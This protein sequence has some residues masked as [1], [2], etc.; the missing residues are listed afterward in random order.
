[1]NMNKEKLDNIEAKLYEILNEI[2]E[3][4]KQLK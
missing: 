1:M 3:Q 4:K 2:N